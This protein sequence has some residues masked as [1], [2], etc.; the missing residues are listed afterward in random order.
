LERFAVLLGPVAP[1]LAEECWQII[2]NDKSLFENPFWF[3]YDEKALIKDTV[4]IAVQVNGK[5]RDTI[6]AAAE[7]DQDSVK[8]II[9]ENDR[10]TKHLEGKT[11]VR[12]IFVKNKIYNIVVK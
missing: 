3:G 8:K 10:V 6:E 9:M 5:L 2:G 4:N 12:E 1:H 7:S 11:I